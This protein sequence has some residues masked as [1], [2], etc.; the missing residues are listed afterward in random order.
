VKLIAYSSP[1]PTS[2]ISTRAPGSPRA[3][4]VYVPVTVGLE[5]Y[6]WMYLRFER[7]SHDAKTSVTQSKGPIFFC[8]IHW[9]SKSD[10]RQKVVG[11]NK[12]RGIRLV[13]D[14]RRQKLITKW[15]RL[16]CKSDTWGA[17][18]AILRDGRT[19]ESKSNAAT[20]AGFF[21]LSSRGPP[22]A[23]LRVV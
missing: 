17:R 1:D 6:R 15:P 14:C 18:G 5:R 4:S 22:E 21:S 2:G 23:Q 3:V 20:I 16:T 9:F 8:S 7:G 11:E 10:T 13:T 19:R 12:E